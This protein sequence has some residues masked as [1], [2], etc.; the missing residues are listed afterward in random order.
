MRPR[1]MP[2][3]DRILTSSG[4]AREA[5]SLKPASWMYARSVEYTGGVENASGAD[6]ATDVGERPNVRGWIAREHDQIGIHSCGHSS[7]ARRL[8]E[9]GRRCGRQR[10]Q[11]LAPCEPG[12]CPQLVLARGIVQLGGPDGGP[13]QDL[14]A[15]RRIL[16]DRGE[17]PVRVRAVAEPRPRGTER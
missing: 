3:R 17:N 5:K 8:T 9:S 16:A 13:E 12:A 10:R 1:R 14:P 4:T 11:N 15:M 2:C 6:R 7:A